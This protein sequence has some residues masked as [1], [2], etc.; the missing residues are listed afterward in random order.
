MADLFPLS[1]VA[2]MHT[3][4]CEYSSESRLALQFDN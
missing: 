4:F 1:R 3:F 2:Q